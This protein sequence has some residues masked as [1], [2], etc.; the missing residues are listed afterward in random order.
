MLF[1]TSILDD[2]GIN[3]ILDYGSG[4]PYSP[5]KQSKE[6]Q[7]NTERQ[8][9]TIT[10][11]LIFDKRISLSGN[12]NLTFFVW[13]YNL[14]DRKNI[15]GILSDFIDI[16]W[17]HNYKNTQE[18]YENGDMSYA[19]YMSIMDQQDPNDIDGDGIYTE[20]DGEVDYNKKHPEMGDSLNPLVYARSRTI[21][22]GISID[23]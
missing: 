13:V 21:R 3:L 14:L 2:A 23:F 4:R 1:N 22:F 17:Y 12:R 15:D 19:D 8:P 20:A 16:N 9:W 11:D 5:P 18:S 6:P 7:I 10:L